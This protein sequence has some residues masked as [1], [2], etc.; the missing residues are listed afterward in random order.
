MRKGLVTGKALWLATL[1]ILSLCCGPVRG[2]EPV[3]AG[4]DLPRI[5]LQ[6]PESAEARKYLGLKGPDP[7]SLSDI[8][9]KLILMEVFYI[10]CLDCQKT[11]PDL[12]K[13]FTFIRNDPELRENLK[14][15]GL[16]IRSDHKKLRVYGSQ[17]RVT[18]PLLPDP[19][20][21]VFEKLGEP[22]IPC[23]ILANSRGKVLLTHDGPLKSAEGFFSEI[24]KLYQQQ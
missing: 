2:A 8:P 18:F 10:L 17:F 11:A 14:M 13:L 16:G 5:T 19:E 12:N 9:A 15:F 22:K 21:E 1:F 6:P 7:F 20:N 24:K 4:M 23:L 3:A